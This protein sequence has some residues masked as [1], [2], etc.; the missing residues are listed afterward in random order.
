VVVVPE[1]E[2]DVEFVGGEASPGAWEGVGDVYVVAVG[3]LRVRGE[4]EAGAG[5]KA[6][7]DE[8]GWEVEA[9]G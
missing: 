8:E 7:V 4:E 2:C 5:G 3:A 9:E 1:Q 6:G